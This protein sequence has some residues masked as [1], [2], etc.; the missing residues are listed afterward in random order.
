M[1]MLYVDLQFNLTL[2][3]LFILVFTWWHSMIMYVSY[4]PIK[5]SGFK[6]GVYP[7]SYIY[8]GIGYRSSA[9]FGRM[10]LHW[11]VLFSGFKPRISADV[12]CHMH[13]YIYILVWWFVTFFIVPY[14]GNVI[15]P[16]D[17]HIFQR[18]RHTTNQYIYIYTVLYIYIY[19]IIYIYTVLYIYSIIYIYYTVLYIYILYSIK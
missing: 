5:H 4:Q 3:L 14:L 9:M 7:G 16:T 8:I 10:T 1:G 17:F 2:Q 12:G 6:Q 13:I 11:L 19:S 18:G 15:I